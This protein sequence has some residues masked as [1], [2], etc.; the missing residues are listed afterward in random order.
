MTRFSDNSKP[1]AILGRRARGLIEAA[2]PPKRRRRNASPLI[3]G[4]CCL[5][6]LPSFGLPEGGFLFFLGP[7]FPIRA[8]QKRFWDAEPGALLRQPSRR[9]EEGA[10][11]MSKQKILVVED[12]VSLLKLESILLAT[13]GYQVFSKDNG[14]D[15]LECVEKEMPDLLLLDVMLPGVDGFEVCR[16]I[17]S[18]PLTSHIL[19][20]LLTAKRAREDV[21][22]GKEVKADGYITKPFQAAMV[23][24]TIQELLYR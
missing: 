24:K 5:L 21:A 20:V 8:N 14:K 18:N 9:R 10:H 11:E 4:H 23:I 19:V 7:F 3:S 6:L 1:E 2:Q 16:Q 17:K 22:M 13:R 12:D 15:A